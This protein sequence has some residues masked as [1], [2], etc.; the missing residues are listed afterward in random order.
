MVALHGGIV[1]IASTLG[2]RTALNVRVPF[3]TAHLL[4]DRID[5]L[6]APASTATL[7]EAFVAEA[8]RWLPEAASEGETEAVFSINAATQ[9][10]S[11]GARPDVVIARPRVLHYW[12]FSFLL[13][14]MVIHRLEPGHHQYTPLCGFCRSPRCLSVARQGCFVQHAAI[15]G[16]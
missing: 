9:V 3:G 12:I 8:L 14:R 16:V 10:T 11:H 4:A 1:E 13:S 5:A 6:P 15:V 7:A 2:G